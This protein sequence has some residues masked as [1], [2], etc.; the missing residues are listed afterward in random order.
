MSKEE[1]Y[2]LAIESISTLKDLS[3]ASSR[4]EFWRERWEHAAAMMDSW[5]KELERLEAKN[6]GKAFEA[7]PYTRGY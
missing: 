5:Q 4:V 1:A 2:K 6:R 7:V 3:Y